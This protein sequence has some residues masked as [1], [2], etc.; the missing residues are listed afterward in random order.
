M[1]LFAREHCTVNEDDV[2][3]DWPLG[4]A[5]RRARER[6]GRSVRDASRR[7]SQGGGRPAVSPGWWHQL[8]SGWQ[9]NKGIR[10][11]IGTTAAT[12]AAAAA[13]VDWDIKEA[14]AIAG[15]DPSEIEATQENDAIGRYSDDELLD[16][17]RRR[18]ASA[19]RT[20]PDDPQN[21]TLRTQ[22]RGPDEEPRVLG[23]KHGEQRHQG[24]G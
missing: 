6:A 21:G 13:A 7:T 18:M 20:V 14:L 19:R 23:D 1:H 9:V 22:W 11:P 4:P 24:R 2:R 12:V 10:I 16:E 15:F 17:V 3:E 8:E 5:L